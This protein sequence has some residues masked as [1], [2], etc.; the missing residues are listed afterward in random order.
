MKKVILVLSLLSNII[1]CLASCSKKIFSTTLLG[2]D[3]IY[4][5]TLKIIVK[6]N[7]ILNKSHIILQKGNLLEIRYSKKFSDSIK[8][9][10]PEEYKCKFIW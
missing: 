2:V 9:I 5:D 1:L 4:E 3:G 6:E 7:T 8:I 10:L